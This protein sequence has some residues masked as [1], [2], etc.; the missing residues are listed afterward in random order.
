[1][2]ETKVLEQLS[3]E[4]NQLEQFDIA[5]IPDFPDDFNVEDMNQIWKEMNK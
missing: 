4:L 1:M 3:E 5:D 2:T